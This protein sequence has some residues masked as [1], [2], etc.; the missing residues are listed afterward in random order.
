MIRAFSRHERDNI[1][2]DYLWRDF[3]LVIVFYKYSISIPFYKYSIP[4]GWRSRTKHT[5]TINT[6]KY[7]PGIITDGLWWR[8]QK[9]LA[10]FRTSFI[11]IT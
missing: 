2:F 7:S 11:K 4:L 8:K 9:K 6:F 1:Q 3:N 10:L 5:F